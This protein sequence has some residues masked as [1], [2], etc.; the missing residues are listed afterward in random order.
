MSDREIISAAADLLADIVDEYKDLLAEVP[1]TEIVNY[2]IENDLMRDVTIVET[3]SNILD[4][5]KQELIFR[6]YEQYDI[7]EIEEMERLFISS[8]QNKILN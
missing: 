2:V 1:D 7:T 5:L 4:E 6:L 3:P 8:K